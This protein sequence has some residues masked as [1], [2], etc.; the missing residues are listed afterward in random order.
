M[1]EKLLSRT[2][3]SVSLLLY[4]W[5]VIRENNRDSYYLNL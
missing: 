3:E 5:G 2:T 4:I 1:H